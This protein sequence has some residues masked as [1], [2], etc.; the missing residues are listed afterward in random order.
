MLNNIFEY[1]NPKI[2]NLIKLS[3]YLGRS[4][5]EN[6]ELFSVDGDS[7]IFLTESNYLIKGKFDNSD[8]LKLVNLVVEDADTFKDTKKFDTFVKGK[9][10]G[11]IK[12]IYEDNYKKA[13]S[14]FDSVLSLFENKVKFRSTV[15]SLNEKVERTKDFSNILQTEQ[16]EKLQ[17]I[18]PKLIDYLKEHSHRIKKVS[19][20]VNGVKLSNIISKAFNFPYM[21]LETLS[22]AG[23]YSR[24]NAETDTIYE[25]VCRQELLKQEL[26]ESKKSFTDLW[27]TNSNFT[28]LVACIYKPTEL[29]ET[30]AKVINEIPFVAFATKKQLTE[31]IEA[32]LSVVEGIDISQKEIKEF[33]ATLFELKKPVRNKFTKILN[34]K[35]GINLQNLKSIP[36]FKSLLNTQVVIFESLARLSPKNS[37]QKQ[38]LSEFAELLKIKNGVESVDVNDYLFDVFESAGYDDILEEMGLTDY[39]DFNRVADDLGQIGDILRMLKQQAAGMQGGGGGMNAPQ[40][41]PQAGAQQPIQGQEGEMMTRSPV[42]P[43]APELGEE[44]EE[45]NSPIPDMQTSPGETSDPAMGAEDAAMEAE[46]EFA[47]AVEDEE[48]VEPGM[49]DP[50]MEG[51]V[52]LEG[53]MGIGEED[54]IETSPEDVDTEELMANI[55]E[56]EDLLADLTSELE[57]AGLDV[58]GGMEGEE[59]GM[60]DEMGGEEFGEEEEFGDE[61]PG[62]ELPEDEN[63]DDIHIDI[64]SH[65]DE[66]GDD[67]EEFVPPKK[68]K[69]FPK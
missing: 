59:L 10:D 29:N 67:E 21:S 8:G 13:S 16:F 38:V 11:L 6:V 44:P 36:T 15:A 42:S 20:V 66:D 14:S 52:D 51:E 30:Y 61:E 9:I 23:S 26:L 60:E 3:D 35:Y 49:G 43:E 32:A 62:A 50:G 27:A 31:T 68:K 40:A 63:D 39:L 47:G 33:V 37:I 41:N 46:D 54:D 45:E 1:R 28:D 2:T 12:H 48:G 17:E 24:N 69:K 34:E 64:N 4:L 65:D 57:G 5:R 56:L 55:A 7:V 18:T 25:M 58:E 19:E 22:E 53:E